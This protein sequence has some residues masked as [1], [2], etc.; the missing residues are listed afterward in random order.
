MMNLEVFSQ[1][2]I[3]KKLII[4]KMKN[5]NLILNPIYKVKKNLKVILNL[6]C[7]VKYQNMKVQRRVNL[8]K[9]LM[10]IN[11]MKLMKNLK[12]S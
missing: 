2:I 11:L 3:F 12:K 4:N 1:K 8:V 10:K 7:K 9:V 6:I 5:L